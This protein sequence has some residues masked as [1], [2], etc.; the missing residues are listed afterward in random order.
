MGGNTPDE[1][2]GRA[3]AAVDEGFTAIKFDPLPPGFQDMGVDR[4][5]KVVVDNTAAARDTVGPDVDIILEIHR[6]LTPMYSIALAEAL[7]PFNI[8]FYE[9]PLQIDSIISQ[10]EIAQRIRIPLANGERMH[11]IWEFR[12]L[13]AHGGSQYVRP[14]LGAAG[15]LFFLL[16]QVELARLH[17]PKDLH[18]LP[19]FLQPHQEYRF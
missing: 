16:L 9:D 3:K 12:E 10:A 14:D 2:S 8:L 5:I 6:K 17:F 19:A 18:K 7:V 4:L 11:S 1:I 15:G 13:L